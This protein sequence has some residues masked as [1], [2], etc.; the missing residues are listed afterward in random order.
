MYLIAGKYSLKGKSIAMEIYIIFTS[1][2]QR[3]IILTV[4][5]RWQEFF[6]W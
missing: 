1:N 5:D 2:I 4:S 3:E 6:G